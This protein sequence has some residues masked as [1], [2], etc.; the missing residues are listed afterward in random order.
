M[1][2][3]TV[4]VKGIIRDETPGGKTEEPDG[5]GFWRPFVLAETVASNNLSSTRT[6]PERCGRTPPYNKS[7]IAE[8]L[9]SRPQRTYTCSTRLRRIKSSLR[10]LHVRLSTSVVAVFSAFV[11]ASISRFSWVTSGSGSVSS[12]LVQGEHINRN[13]KVGYHTHTR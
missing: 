5:W 11:A 1:V 4:K 8:P 10:S 2:N 12:S 7:K 3:A 13:S 9:Q 6:Q